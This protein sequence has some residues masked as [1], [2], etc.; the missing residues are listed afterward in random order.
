[1][2]LAHMYARCKPVAPVT[3]TVALAGR[4]EPCNS[5]VAMDVHMERDA[6]SLRVFYGND[7]YYV[8]F[9]LHQYLYDRCA[10]AP[11]RSAAV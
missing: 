2:D 9:R 3:R 11:F 10:P 8:L 4:A 5:G 6:H 7:T 1:M